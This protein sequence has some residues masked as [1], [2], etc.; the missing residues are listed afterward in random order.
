MPAIRV[1]EGEIEFIVRADHLE[2]VRAAQRPVRAKNVDWDVAGQFAREVLALVRRVPIR[3]QPRH[4]LRFSCCPVLFMR[5]PPCYSYV[6]LTIIILNKRM[7]PRQKP[8]STKSTPTKSTP[9]KI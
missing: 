9:I 5:P 1:F 8:H 7:G 2:A 3:Y 6:E 4:F